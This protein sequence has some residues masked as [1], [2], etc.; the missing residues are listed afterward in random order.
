MPGFLFDHLQLVRTHSKEDLEFSDYQ[1]SY[2][3]VLFSHGAGTTMEV[4]TSQCEDLANHGYVVA[5]VDHTYVSAATDLDGRLV[6]AREATKNF[7]TPEP[8]EPITQ[9]W[10]MTTSSSPAYCAI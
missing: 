3:V 6:T 9:S 10:R 2:P 5:A 8:A 1:P 7:D 4:A